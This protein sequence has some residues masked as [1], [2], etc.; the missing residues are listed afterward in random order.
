MGGHAAAHG[1]DALR[2]VHAL[3]V[4]GAGLET[5]EDDLLAAL[6]PVGGRLSG[7]HDLAAG[8]AGGRREARADDLGLL[9]GRGVERRVEQGVEAL[10][11]DHGDGLFLGDHAL[12]DQI[13][14]DLHR[15]GRG[16]LAVSGLEHVELLVFNREFH[17]LHVAVVVL[18]LVADVHELRIGLGHDLGQLLDAL[19]GAD[20][21]DDV[22]ALGIH[23]EL[24]EQLLLAGGGVAREG[25]A[26]AGRIAGVAEDHGLDVDGGAPI[27]GD[28]VHA[29][30]V[31]RARVVPAAEHG[32]DG[33]H[34]LF[35]RVLR[36]LFAELFLIL[37]L[38]LF[39]QLL[40]V[41][42][43]QLGIE[44]DVAGDL[45]LVDELLEIL[46]AHFHDDVGIH[47]DEPA[48]GV[49]GET[50]IVGLLGERD[51]DLVIQAK[52][53]DG[54]HHAGHRRACAGADGD[55]QRVVEIAELLAGHLF[56]LF[57]VLHDLRLDLMVDL[58]VILVVLRASFGGD[59]EALRDRHAKAGHFGQIGAL[60]AEQLAHFTV[61]FGEQIYVL[62]RH[63]V[64]PFPV[65]ADT[66][67]VPAQCFCFIDPQ[68]VHTIPCFPE[69]ANKI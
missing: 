63:L 13:A 50:G 65:R 28:V 51:D 6:A 3:D 58:A 57:H 46:L 40:E 52:V 61:A 30:I 7:E 1:Q 42:S 35:L 44:L 67:L 53:Q 49:V 18:Q 21:G 43:G 8:R 59:G 25:D 31:D 26:R 36:E 23:Q 22:F 9:Q 2:I 24:T 69:N 12:V 55:Q 56:E 19:R 34:Q 48:V 54:I 37:G 29:A 47:L 20:A 17:V 27:G 66:S 68:T 64:Y 41:L 39:G 60:A 16:A 33:A 15:G 38:E 45:H 5:N 14:G 10:R 32:L 4:L 62:V 11:V